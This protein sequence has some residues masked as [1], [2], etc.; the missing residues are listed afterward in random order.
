MNITL[1][2]DEI[3]RANISETVEIES[4]DNRQAVRRDDGSV[5]FLDEFSSDAYWTYMTHRERAWYKTN[6]YT[7]RV[8]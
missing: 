2:A 3:K 6:P 8:Q 7:G 1:V 4:I 5:F